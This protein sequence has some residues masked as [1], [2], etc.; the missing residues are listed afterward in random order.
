MNAIRY[1]YP[2]SEAIKYLNKQEP[3]FLTLLVFSSYSS[4]CKIDVTIN[5]FLN[6]IACEHRLLLPKYRYRNSGSNAKIPPN[7]RGSIQ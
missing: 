1:I 4:I 7:G 6:L 2:Y 3:F 5:V